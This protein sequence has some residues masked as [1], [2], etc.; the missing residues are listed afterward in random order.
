MLLSLLLRC[1]SAQNG[2][3]EE[4]FIVI[5]L[6]FR[7]KWCTQNGFIIAVIPVIIRR[8]SIIENNSTL[9]FKGQDACCRTAF[10]PD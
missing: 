7:A 6:L 9:A 5:A 3:L 1:L 10:M 2:I 4:G 8:K